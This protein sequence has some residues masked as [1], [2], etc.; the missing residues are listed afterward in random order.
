MKPAKKMG[1][2]SSML[3]VT[4]IYLLGGHDDV[5]DSSVV[6]HAQFHL[7]GEAS[8]RVNVGDKLI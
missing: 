6:R 4:E 5:D 1:A 3:F 7:L 2:I 8:S